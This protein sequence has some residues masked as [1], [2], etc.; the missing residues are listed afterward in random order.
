[1]IHSSSGMVGFHRRQHWVQQVSE[2]VQAVARYPPVS[3]E[4]ALSAHL[5]RILAKAHDTVTSAV[6]G[7]GV[8]KRR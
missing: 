8:T 6:L 2:H 7:W 1:M 3:D 5:S 4:S